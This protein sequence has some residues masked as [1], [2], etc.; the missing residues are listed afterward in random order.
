MNFIKTLFNRKR[1]KTLEL[2]DCMYES[3]K[4]NGIVQTKEEFAKILEKPLINHEIDTI[5]KSIEN[6]IR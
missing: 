6:K 3:A 4:N 1:D 5:L 2:F